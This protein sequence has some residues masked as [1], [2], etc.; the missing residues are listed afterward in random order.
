MK[1]SYIKIWLK[2]IKI[3]VIS[4]ATLTKLISQSNEINGQIST[5]ATIYNQSENT[6]LNGGIRLIPDL[7]LST[8]LTEESF[9]D[10]N[11]SA[12]AFLFKTENDFTSKL[13]LYR[14]KLRYATSQSELRFGLQK[15]NFGPARIL[16][17]LRWFDSV[18]PTDPLKLT[19][20]VYG[21]R[22]KYNFLNNS[23]IW[24]W[25]LYGNDN[26]RGNDFLISDNKTP[27]FG[28]RVSVPFLDGEIAGTF[29]SRKTNSNNLKINETKF[30]LDGRWEIEAGIWFEAVIS[31]F[32]EN[33]IIPKWQNNL[34]IGSDYTFNIGNGLLVTAEHFISRL[35]DNFMIDGTSINSSAVSTSY[36]FGL[37]DNFAAFVFYNWKVKKFYQTYQWNR[38][39]DSFILNFN[40]YHYPETALL[41][42]QNNSEQT[43][44]GYGFQLLIIY[45]F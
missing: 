20:G 44:A 8:D 25:L 14:I 34:T 18:D 5:W 38:V 39:Y 6:L 12:N 31:K 27:E 23:E 1:N 29:H 10:L 26:L 45:N 2:L 24:F 35:S 11:I 21:I 16:R 42:S 9:L 32:E 40:F 7:T 17:S 43:R 37:I 15:I 13:D 19:Q 30:A 41:Y 22:Y 28:S 3:F 36:A 33:P 4:L